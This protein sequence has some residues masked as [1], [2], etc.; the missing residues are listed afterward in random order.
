MFTGRFDHSL[1][2]K[3][4]ASI[5][6]R[7]RELLLRESHDRL[8][9]TNFFYNKEKCLA[10]YPPTQW[11]KLNE[12]LATKQRFDP[13]MQAFETFL[14]GGAFEV[15]VD[16]QGRILIPERLRAWAGLGREVV[17]SARPDHFELW[18]KQVLDR[19]IKMSE[20]QVSDPEFLAKLGI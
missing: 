15:P 5:P 9:V 13:R 14:I 12:M 3:G 11:D 17:F 7:F 19:V 20:E 16:R 2:D 18:N 1:D 8:Y 6:A 10:L 4:R